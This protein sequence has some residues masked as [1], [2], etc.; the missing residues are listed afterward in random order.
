MSRQRSRVRKKI[1]PQR[2]DRRCETLK[3]CYLTKADALDAV[4]GQ[5]LQGRVSPG[6]HLMP[7]ECDQCRYWHIANRQ[8]VAVE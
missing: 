6:C 2:I 8:I 5:M 3:I 1:D 4:E 7:Y